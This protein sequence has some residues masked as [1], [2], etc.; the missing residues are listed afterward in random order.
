MNKPKKSVNEDSNLSQF[1]V[2]LCQQTVQPHYEKHKVGFTKT[3]AGYL[4][5]RTPSLESL[6]SWTSNQIDSKGSLFS[7]CTQLHWAREKQN[8]GEN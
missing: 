4:V 8:F 3:A 5:Q 7:E 1:L 6:Q 2:C